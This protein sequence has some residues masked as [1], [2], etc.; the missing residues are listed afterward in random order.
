MQLSRDS[1]EKAFQQVVRRAFLLPEIAAVNVRDVVLEKNADWQRDIHR[2]VDAGW[3]DTMSDVDMCVVVRKNPE[4]SISEE[5]YMHRLDRFGFGV[6]NCL[7]RCFVQGNKMARI[8]TREGMRYDFGFSFVT[9]AHAPFWQMEQLPEETENAHWSLS[10]ME[11]FWFVQVQALAKLYRR[12][13]LIADHLAHMNLNETLV[14]QMVLRD[15]EKGTCHHRYGDG[16]AAVYEK[17][18]ACYQGQKQDGRFCII[19]RKLYA[20][21]MAYDELMQ[22]FYPQVH[23][24]SS[25]FFSLW[26]AYDAGMA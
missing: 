22:I 19:A 16:E 18:L 3:H 15:I 20:A 2:A 9:E 7:G 24:R 12:D 21:A 23:K 13:Y 4:E 14:Q 8:I 25:I 26:N 6:E 10:K 11:E 5:T 1:V 17:Y